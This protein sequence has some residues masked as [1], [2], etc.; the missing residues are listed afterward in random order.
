MPNLITPPSRTIDPDT[1]LARRLDQHARD[2][3]RLLGWLGVIFS[4][5]GLADIALGWYPAA[6]GNTEWE[7][8]TISGSL[9]ALTIPMMGL[10]LVVASAV[11][12]HDH[13]S[14]RVLSILLWLMVVVLVGL[15]LI[16]LTVIPIALK[17]VANNQ[18]VLLGMQ[19]A[20]VKGLVLLAGYTLLLV[21]GARRI[22]RVREKGA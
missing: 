8:G 12:R 20:I 4:I 7:F 6:F 21:I 5:L 15:G 22:G 16:Y 2:A 11:A 14:A 19:K 17:A 18:L 3:W 9:N 13:R 1:V 10:Y